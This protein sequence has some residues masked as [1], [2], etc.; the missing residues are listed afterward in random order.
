M[1]ILRKIMTTS[2][3][4]EVQKK[5]KM[6]CVKNGINM[7]EAIETFMYDYCGY[8]RESVI[9]SKI[10]K[11]LDRLG[12]KYK[13]IYIDSTC[14]EIHEGFRNGVFLNINL[15]EY[16]MLKQESVIEIYDISCVKDGDRIPII[17]VFKSNSD[18]ELF[19]LLEEV[20]AKYSKVGDMID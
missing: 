18:E 11:L 17:E 3:D 15:L 10:I 7:N 16:N 20:I 19:K 12:D 14:V 6:E 1:I 2:I 13:I 5:F 8:A 4:E 9:S